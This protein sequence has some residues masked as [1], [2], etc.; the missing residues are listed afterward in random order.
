MNIA[1]YCGSSFGASKIYE[2]KTKAL[3]KKLYENSIQIVYGG[4][5]QGLMGTISN[6]SLKYGNKVTGVI[7]NDLANKEIE[8]KS[9]QEIY[10]VH[11]INDRKEKMEEL[12][13][14]FIAL[15]GGYGTF[16]EI[17]EVISL[18][19]MGYHKKPCA[20][21]NINGYYDNLLNFL[22]NVSKEGFI[23]K[24]FIDMLIIT[25]D[26]DELILEIKHYKAPLAKWE[27]K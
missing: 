26:I 4:S 21:L 20:F 18:A 19:Q 8:N 24:R 27:D 3:A 7:T 12:S 6:E 10:R 15:P 23:D 22:K 13:D 11:T 2:E 25:D 1:I 14:G 16:D 5:I 17:F 9:L